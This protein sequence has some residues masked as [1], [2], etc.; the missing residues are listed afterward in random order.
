MKIRVRRVHMDE[1]HDAR[2]IEV[3]GAFPY[4]A[5]YETVGFIVSVFDCTGNDLHPVLSALETFQEVYTIAYE[6]RIKVGDISPGDYVHTWMPIGLFVPDAI[7]GPHGGMRNLMS[8][9]RLVNVHSDVTVFKGVVVEGESGVYWAGSTKF[10]CSLGKNGY[11][12][13]AQKRHELQSVIIELAAAVAIADGTLDSDEIK[14]VQRKI[15]NWIEKSESFFDGLNEE[16]RRKS[17]K[18]FVDHALDKATS[19][20]IDINTL[21]EHLS[22]AEDQKIW[23]EAIELCYDVMAA[24][25]EAN[26]EELRI[27]RRMSNVSGINPK[28]IAKIHDRKI[29][30]LAITHQEE[31]PIE[32]LLGIDPNWNPSEIKDYL[33]D[34]YRKWNGRLNTVPPGKSRENAQNMLDIISEAYEKYS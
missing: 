15:E 29:I 3:K 31:T 5:Y 8:I 22:R 10:R 1:V 17:Y 2:Q 14:V 27:L 21:L 23:Y 28:E 16:K 33:R 13:L 12:G 25:G 24:D 26:P 32:E 34:E 30:N 6:S 11:I 19:H 20:Q 18:Q 7:L 9:V 4:Q